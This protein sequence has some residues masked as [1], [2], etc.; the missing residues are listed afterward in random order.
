M[1]NI[2]TGVRANYF[3]K[4]N[5]LCKLMRKKKLKKPSSKT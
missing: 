2:N 4:Q 1:V 3:N 5:K